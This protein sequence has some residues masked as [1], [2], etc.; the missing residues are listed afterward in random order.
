MRSCLIRMAIGGAVWFVAFAGAGFA[1]IQFGPSVEQWLNPVLEKQDVR[2]IT[3]VGDQVCWDWRWTKRKAAVGKSSEFNY[4]LKGVSV[5]APPVITYKDTGE[6]FI[7]TTTIP[8]HA[9]SATLCALL[10][11]TIRDMHGLRIEG[12]GWY[13]MMHGLWSVVQPYPSVPVP[14]PSP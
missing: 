5:A 14:P 8:P 12:Q 9:G 13:R 3:R 1:V 2:N 4:T 6:L 10:P 11:Q 7:H